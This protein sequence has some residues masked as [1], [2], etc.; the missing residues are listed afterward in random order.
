MFHVQVDRVGWWHVIMPWIGTHTNYLSLNALPFNISGPSWLQ[1][2]RTVIL[3]CIKITSQL[4]CCYLRGLTSLMPAD[5]Y[6]WISLLCCNHITSVLEYT[7][8]P[9]SHLRIFI[10]AAS[11]PGA[12]FPVHGADIYHW[13]WVLKHFRE[14]IPCWMKLDSHPIY[15]HPSFSFYLIVF[16]WVILSQIS[17]VYLLCIVY[18]KLRWNFLKKGILCILFTRH[19]GLCLTPECAHKETWKDTV[20]SL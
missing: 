9:S 16:L 4:L 19:L 20:E 7:K 5:L 12:L 14:L 8:L 13:G 1:I 3:H 11:L 2:R 10:P 17:L 6:L 18:F 15:S